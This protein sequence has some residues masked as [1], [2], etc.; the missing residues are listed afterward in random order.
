MNFSILAGGGSR[1]FS[2]PQRSRIAAKQLKSAGFLDKQ[3]N[4]LYIKFGSMHSASS[5]F[6][7]VNIQLTMTAAGVF[8]DNSIEIQSVRLEPYVLESNVGDRI[9]LACEVHALQYLKPEI[10]TQIAALGFFSWF[11]LANF[12]LTSCGHCGPACASKDSKQS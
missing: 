8:S 5:L 9:L 3:S 4:I 6:S 12:T 10:I 1:V 2:G 7:F 11:G